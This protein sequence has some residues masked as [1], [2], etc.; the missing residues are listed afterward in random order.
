MLQH[1][2][3]ADLHRNQI[4]RRQ[5]RH[6]VV[7]LLCFVCHDDVPLLISLIITIPAVMAMIFES[8]LA[9]G[10]TGLRVKPLFHVSQPGF[11]FAISSVTDPLSPNDPPIV[12]GVVAVALA[13]GLYQVGGGTCSLRVLV[14]V[15][16]VRVSRC[17][18]EVEIVLF[19]ILAVVSLAVG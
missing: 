1:E 13:I 18:V 10:P 6:Q 15:L 3:L 12:W 8:Q 14:Q 19:D 7:D 9:D 17:T 4:S 16:Q 2:V 11:Q 5:V